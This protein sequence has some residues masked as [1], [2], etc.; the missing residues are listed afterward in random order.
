MLVHVY[1]ACACI[2]SLELFLNSNFL[3]Y[4]SSIGRNTKKVF[5]VIIAPRISDHHKEKIVPAY[6]FI[7]LKSSLSILGILFLIIFI[8]LGFVVL[9]DQFL[10]LLLSVTGIV[11]SL[12]ISLIYL[13]LRDILSNE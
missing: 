1:L 11:E 4:V 7:L 13:K 8:F 6:A 10:T 3:T 12:V 5:R 9:S 2:L